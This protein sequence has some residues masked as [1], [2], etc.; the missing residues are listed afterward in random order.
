VKNGLIT[1]LM[2]F[3]LSFVAVSSSSAHC[4]TLLQSELASLVENFFPSGT[5]NN[6][7]NIQVVAYAVAC[8][9]SSKR[10][11]VSGD[12]GNS[13]GLWQINVPSHSEYDS[14]QLTDPSYN[15]QS[16]VQISSGGENWRP[17]T[18]WKNGAYKQYVPEAESALG[19]ASQGSVFLIGEKVRVTTGL[20]VRFKPGTSGSM[21]TTMAAGSTGTI[22]EG[23][24]FTEGYTWWKIIYNDGTI[25]WSADN[26]LE[27]V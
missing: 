20:N 2:I 14:N 23:P 26:W 19:V 4:A 21:I 8:A 5:T 22:L 18:T 17:W 27:S 25:G 24:V 6:G 16:A 1:C 15:A 12:N 7:E 9:E 13:I 3:A 11:C 10:P